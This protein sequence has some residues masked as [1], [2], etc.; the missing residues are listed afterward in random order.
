MSDRYGSIAIE[1]TAPGTSPPT[2][3]PPL[4]HRRKAPEKGHKNS[5]K[6]LFIALVV[7][8]IISGYFLTATY[9]LPWAI[10]KYLP[11]FIVNQSGIHLTIE[12]VDLNPLNFQLTLRKIT[13]DTAVPS[14]PSPLLK[15]DS[16]FIDLDFTSLIRNSF[17]CDKLVIDNLALNLIRYKDKSYNLPIL[18]FFSGTQKHGQII[19][20]ASLPFLFSLNNIDINN[21]Q[22]YFED[23]VTD[24][25]HEIEELQL[26]IPTLSNFSFQ[27]ENYITP[28]FS[29]VINGSPIT[30]S[31]KAVQLDDNQGFQTKLSCSIQSLNLVPY[32]S[33]LPASF[34]LTMTQGQADTSLEISFAPN[35]KQGDRLRIDIKMNASDLTFGGKKESLEITIPA[36]TLDAVVMPMAKK[37]HVNDIITKKIR[38][39]A[40]EE[41]TASV[42]HALF[43][44]RTDRTNNKSPTISIDRF[45]TDQ[46]TVIFRSTDSARK[47]IRSQWNEL[48]VSI[49]NFDPQKTS[50]TIHISGEHAG[51][52]GSFSW[53]GDVTQTGSIQGKLLL[54]DFSAT[55][56]I[57]QIAPESRDTV[58]GVA[59][60]SGDLSF[61]STKEE[62][63][64]YTF[65]GGILQFQNLKISHKK[66][67][68]FKAESVRLTRINNSDNTLN[69]GDIFLKGASLNLTSEKLPPLFT[70][71]LT[72]PEHPLIMGIDFSG[73]IQLKRTAKQDQPLKI[74][75]VTFQATRLNNRATTENF[76][77]SGKIPPKGII[78]ARGI[79][80]LTP[81]RIQAKLAFSDLESENFTAFSRGWPLLATSKMSLHGKGVYRFPDSSFQ[82]NLRL[83]DTLLQNSGK[84][85]LVSWDTAEFNNVTCHFTPFSLQAESLLLNTPQFQWTRSDLSPF[86]HIQKGLRT[87]STNASSDKE[88]PLAVDIKKINFR[89]ATVHFTDKRLFPAWSGTFKGLEGWINDVNTTGNNLSSFAIRGFLDE[90]PL[91]FSGSTALFNPKVE[92]HAKMTLSDFPL[93]NF[94]R[95]FETAPIDPVTAELDLNLTMT[96][97]VS[98]FHS[99]SELLLKKLYARSTNSTTALALAVMKDKSD[100][101]SM[102]VVIDLGSKSLL[103][104]GLASF[105]TTVIKASYAPLLLD[106]RFKDLQ[107]KGFISFLPGSNKL[108]AAARSILSR[109]G[110]LLKEHPGLGLL[111]TGMADGRK[112]R[113]I[114]KKEKEN[115]EQQRVDGINKVKLAEHRQKQLKLAAIQPSNTIKEENISKEELSDFTPVPPNPVH[116]S[117]RDLLELAQERSLIVHDFLIHS[118]NIAPERL[119]TKNKVLVR[120]NPSATGS[121]IEIK[122]VMVKTNRPN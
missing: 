93:K 6:S 122:A 88:N 116:I 4:P 49:K 2:E 109:Y 77:F 55:T 67:P 120:E 28:H 52:M 44:P 14:T 82:G 7:F 5:R 29:A 31:G 27:S 104:Q 35:R 105:Q 114:L 1:P 87:L 47:S 23:Q 10:Q 71:L 30:L 101:F 92:G 25:T 94:A 3:A 65:A 26:A 32:F 117:D 103:Q 21:S 98:Q 118:L 115:I 38:V 17:T 66:S 84:T 96:E 113:D 36:L 108:E 69:L 12:K 86:Q 74:R 63:L 111:I 89:D 100:S 73:D 85:T 39:S 22:I 64:S 42:L 57:Q 72:E 59:S 97:T 106:R 79:L 46:A 33:Y 112:D 16:L 90:S 83:S 99:E 56:F 43:F 58:A 110:D 62:Q 91:T 102:K 78:K 76:A 13:A 8:F 24:K 121:S 60:F 68:W 45:L 11:Q 20:F 75:S 34:P 48:Q 37:F 95:Q 54:N 15:I 41:F 53:Q 119:S 50:G 70:R 80:N 61:H 107:D 81:S 18:S 19:D 51:D 40:T 9:F